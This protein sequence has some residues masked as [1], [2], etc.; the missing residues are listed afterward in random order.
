M[1]GNY[2]LLSIALFTILRIILLLYLKPL[3][4]MEI[5]YY[6]S[7]SLINLI[8]TLENFKKTS[9]FIM[10]EDKIHTNTVRPK[11]NNTVLKK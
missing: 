3:E 9:S 10:P 1:S 11:N 4:L 2:E 8:K 5:L 7:T 6:Y